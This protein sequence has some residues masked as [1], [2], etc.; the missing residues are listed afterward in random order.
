[1]RIKLER[2]ANRLNKLNIQVEFVLNYP[3]VYL[4]KVNNKRVKELYH[5][6]HGFTICFI[7][8]NK[9]LNRKRLFKKIRE[10]L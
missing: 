10:Y 8:D 6:N 2:L 5:S 7:N 9:F 4:Y 1:M 3:W